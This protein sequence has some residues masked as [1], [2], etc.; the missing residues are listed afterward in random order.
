MGEG[1]P[2]RRLSVSPSRGDLLRQWF[3]VLALLLRLAVSHAALGRWRFGCED[4]PFAAVN[5]NFFAAETDQRALLDFLFASTDVR[6]F[7]SYSE[8]DADLREFRSTDD[9]ASAFPIGLDPHGN[10]YAV[11]LFLCSP[12]VVRKPTIR[13]FALDPAKCGGAT[14]RHHI[15]GP[16]LMRLYLGGVCGRAITTSN[17]GRTSSLWAERQGRKGTDWEAFKKISDRITY[18]VRKRLAVGKAVPGC[19][20]LPE[21]MELAMAGY[22]LKQTIQNPF[23]YVLQS[24]G[25]TA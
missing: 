21:A 12:S 7:E 24:Q 4:T 16:E 25:G 20:V 22:A 17:F 19:A 2:A 15:E 18:H 1:R 11:T 6:V 23:Q 10:G 8:P 13:R 14:F 5:L 3:R 9:L